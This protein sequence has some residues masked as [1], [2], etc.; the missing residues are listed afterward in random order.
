LAAR[1]QARSEIQDLNSKL[2]DQIA[3]LDGRLKDAQSAV[4]RHEDD[5]KAMQKSRDEPNAPIIAH[6]ATLDNDAGQINV[7]RS[8]LKDMI[9]PAT[10]KSTTRLDDL[11][12][13]LKQLQQLTSDSEE[14]LKVMEATNRDST[15]RLDDV[16]NDVKKRLDDVVNDVKKL[17]QLTSRPNA[18]Q[19]GP[20]PKDGTQ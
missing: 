9:E 18:K 6:L 13:N 1:S 5:I 15:T 3:G 17:Q 4:S 12:S 2:Q 19:P 10:Q 14:K 16:V 20:S 11:Q 7:L 8:R